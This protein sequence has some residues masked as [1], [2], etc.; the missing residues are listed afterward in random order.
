MGL[1]ITQLLP[2]DI[3]IGGESSIWSFPFIALG[4]MPE[5]GCTPCSPAWSAMAARSTWC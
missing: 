4:Y 3:R 5:L 1:G 2:V